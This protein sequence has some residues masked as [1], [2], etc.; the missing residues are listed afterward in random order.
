MSCAHMFRRVELS[1]TTIPAGWDSKPEYTKP[2]PRAYFR[3]QA[4][5][6]KFYPPEARDYKVRMAT[7]ETYP[8]LPSLVLCCPVVS[9]VSSVR[10]CCWFSVWSAYSS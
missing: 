8:S 10:I 3:G 1:W 7:H 4:G 2:M 6:S 9:V 5:Y